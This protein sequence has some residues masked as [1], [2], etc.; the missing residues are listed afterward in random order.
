MTSS[1]SPVAP[2]GPPADPPPIDPSRVATVVVNW[3]DAPATAACLHALGRAG[4]AGPSVHVVDDGSNDDSVAAIRAAHPGVTIVELAENRGTAGGRNAGIRAALDAGCD[5]VLLVDGAVDVAPGCLP[6]LVRALDGEP[7]AAAAASAVLG[8]D[9]TTLDVAWEDLTFGDGVTRRRGAGAAL[10]GDFAAARAV[11]VCAGASVLVRAAAL[12]GVGLFD[13]AYFAQHEV[14]D[15]CVRARHGGWVVLYEPASAVTRRAAPPARPDQAYLRARNAI[16]VVRAHGRPADAVRFVASS[17]FALP[18][19][20]LAI[21]ARQEDA[22]ARG[23]WTYRTA[24][25]HVR[26]ARLP[27]ALAAAHRER[28]TAELVAYVRGLWDGVLGRPLPLHRLG[29]YG[30]RR[31]RPER[32]VIVVLNWNGADDTIACLESLAGADLRGARVLVVDNGSRD[33]SVERIRQRLPDQWILSLPRNEGYAGGNDAGI[34]EALA[35]GAEAVLL[36]NNDTTVAPD[37]LTTLV[38]ALNETE[39]A[40]AVASAVMRMDVPELLDV[41]YLEV[42]LELHGV[43]RLQGVNALPSEGYET[44]RVV[45]VGTGCSLLVRSDAFR[46]VGLLDADFF[47]YHEEVDWC[48]RARLPSRVAQ[49]GPPPAAPDAGAGARGRAAAQRGGDQHPVEPGTDLPRRPEL[50]PPDPQA[51]DVGRE[52]E[53]RRLDARGHPALAVGDVDAAGGTLS[54]ERLAL[55]RLP[56]RVLRPASRRRR[57]VARPRAGVVA[58]RRGGAARPVA[59]RPLPP[60]RRPLARASRGAHRGDGGARPR[61]RR[62]RARARP[63]ARAPRPP[64]TRRGS[65]WTSRTRPW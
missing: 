3:N 19:H 61:P 33:G 65:P 2:S 47:A 4:V 10:A 50:H 32:V 60:A 24:L 49:H 13:E 12:R 31:L 27:R 41:A 34:R 30:V 36:L 44:R 1:P 20:L 58:S 59:A 46:R 15:W 57:G 43:V 28:R 7:R 48:I 14:T 54:P 23:A 21:A 39:S 55:P 35:A 22:V 37:F 5:A 17:V 8:A 63:P 29:L 64:M 9:G 26:P 56:A 6:A 42:H 38:Q 11:D 51:R 25:A 52:A 45:D 18:L 40:A 62:R 53:L 16:R